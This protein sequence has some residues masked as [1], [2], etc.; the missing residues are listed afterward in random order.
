MPRHAT[1][2][3][4]LRPTLYAEDHHPPPPY[5]YTPHTYHELAAMACAVASFV[6]DGYRVH[7]RGLERA[8]LRV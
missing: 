1:P 6:I 3:Y 5:Y 2:P 4:A 8:V 7:V